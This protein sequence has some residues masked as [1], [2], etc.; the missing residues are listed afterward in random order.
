MTTTVST[1]LNINLACRHSNQGQNTRINIY[2]LK[3][4]NKVLTA[5]EIEQNYNALR[6]RYNI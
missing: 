2:N 1:S 5:T 6:G 3:I 4:Y